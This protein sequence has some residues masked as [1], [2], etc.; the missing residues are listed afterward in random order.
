MLKCRPCTQC[1]LQK[2]EIFKAID[3]F[4]TIKYEG[5]SVSSSLSLASAQ[6]DL[7]F[8]EKQMKR[9]MEPGIQY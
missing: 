8:Y 4:I 5:W 6:K 7:N 1:R 9:K 3:M 2:G